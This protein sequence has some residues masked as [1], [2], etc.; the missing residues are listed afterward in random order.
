MLYRKYLKDRFEIRYKR[1]IWVNH[2]LFIDIAL[3]LNPNYETWIIPDYRSGEII[4]LNPEL[5]EEAYGRIFNNLVGNEK[6]DELAFKKLSELVQ[7][8]YIG[9]LA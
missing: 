3:F 6:D 8:E 1:H 4:R 7:V 5:K 2:L 9:V